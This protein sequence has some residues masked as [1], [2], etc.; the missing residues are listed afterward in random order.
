MT[1][2]GWERLGDDHEHA[3]FCHVNVRGNLELEDGN[4]RSAH[5]DG[6]GFGLHAVP[7]AFALGSWCWSLGKACLFYSTGLDPGCLFSPAVRGGM[8]LGIV[9]GGFGSAQE[10]Y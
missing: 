6:F 8:C 3:L 1:T 10:V 7:V 9:T 5:Q 2:L 4:I